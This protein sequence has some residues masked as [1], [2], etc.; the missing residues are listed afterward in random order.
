MSPRGAKRITG[1]YGVATGVYG[2]GAVVTHETSLTGRRK[3]FL[4]AKQPERHGRH[5]VPGAP[6]DDPALE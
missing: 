5:S 4:A 3:C 1:V 2:V 6:T